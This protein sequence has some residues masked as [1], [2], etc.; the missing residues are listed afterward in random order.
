MRGDENIRTRLLRLH[1]P[2]RCRGRWPIW[3]GGR[4]GP[5][6]EWLVPVRVVAGLFDAPPLDVLFVFRLI[7]SSPALRDPVGGPIGVG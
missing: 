4:E 5:A 2:R 7:L 1:E 3:E 6:F